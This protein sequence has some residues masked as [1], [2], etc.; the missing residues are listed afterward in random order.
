MLTALSRGASGGAGFL[1]AGLLAGG[2]GGVGL[3]LKPGLGAPLA[4]APLAT[5]ATTAG[6]GGGGAGF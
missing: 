1:L 5:G 4:T 2:A 6:G 3:A